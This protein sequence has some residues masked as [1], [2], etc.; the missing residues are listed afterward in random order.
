M[1]KSIKQEIINEYL[2]GEISYGQLAKKYKIGKTTVFRWLQTYNGVT[3]VKMVARDIVILP[4]MIQEIRNDLPIEVVELRRQ[5]EQEKLRTK[6]L[7]AIIEIA[8]TELN[9]PIRKKSGTR[10]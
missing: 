10:P 1:K 4:E 3:P 6:L 8:E 9:I 7:T 2:L 5:L